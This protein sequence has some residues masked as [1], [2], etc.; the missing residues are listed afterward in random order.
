METQV[1]VPKERG[2]A[3]KTYSNKY[4][5]AGLEDTTTD[6][7]VLPFLKMLQ[8]LS[9]TVQSGEHRA[10]DILHSTTGEVFNGEEGLSFI[11]VYLKR[12]YLEWIPRER[13]GGLAGKHSPSSPVVQEAKRKQVELGHDWNEFYANDHDKPKVRNELVETGSIY[14]LVLQAS[15]AVSR[16]VIPCKVTHLKAYKTMA[17]MIANLPGP[18]P[19]WAIKFKL[20]TFPDP[21]AKGT[22]YNWKVAYEDGDYLLDEDDPLFEVGR[23]FWE[24]VSGGEVEFDHAKTSEDVSSS[25][26]APQDVYDDDVPF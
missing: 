17:S 22:S 14:G 24:S 4:A 7:Y 2:V 15:G 21:R 19:A 9:K 12:E 18:P 6:D 5:G 23:K 11:P 3:V 26:P 10:G 8:D 16:V 20:N 13:G 1:A 25:A